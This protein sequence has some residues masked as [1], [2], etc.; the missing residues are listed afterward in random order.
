MNGLIYQNH[1][2]LR[3]ENLAQMEEGTEKLLADPEYLD[4]F[5]KGTELLGWTDARQAIYQVF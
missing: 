2:I 4:W 1:V 5:Q 3:Y